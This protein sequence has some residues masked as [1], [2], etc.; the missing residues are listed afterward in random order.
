M[1]LLAGTQDL[2]G[3]TNMPLA[4][5]QQMIV[6]PHF[7]PALTVG[8]ALLIGLELVPCRTGDNDAALVIDLHPL[9][10]QHMLGPVALGP[11]VDLLGALAILDAQ[12]VVA[13]PARAAQAAQHAAGLVRRQVQRHR[14]GAVGQASD[15]Q[16]L[17]HVAI[18]EPHQD[19][20]PDPGIIT[21]P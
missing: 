2:A 4:A 13:S 16:R 3:D 11:Q 5:H 7:C 8:K 19:F 15:D 1:K 9:V 12:F 10:M 20:H 14:V 17:V 21:A 6:L 18:D